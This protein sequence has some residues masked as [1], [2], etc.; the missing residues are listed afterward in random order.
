VAVVERAAVPL[1]TATVSVPRKPDTVAPNVGFAAPYAR[2]A[3]AA[4][5]V[6]GALAI[7]TMRSCVT[8]AALALEPEPVKE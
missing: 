5:T 3:L 7:V 8:P 4:V 6:R 1:T 2:L